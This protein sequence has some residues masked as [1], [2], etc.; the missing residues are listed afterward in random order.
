MT[1]LPAE[2][3]KTPTAFAVRLRDPGFTPSI[4]DVDALVELLADEALARAAERAI[5]RV[6]VAALD[7]LQARLASARPPIR[8]R[9]VRAIARLAKDER[10]AA[11]LLETLEDADP[12]TRRNAAIALGHFDGEP[13]ETALLR[14]WEAD[15]RPEMR[16]SLAASLGKVGTTVALPLLREAARAIDPELARIA[17]RAALMVERTQSRAGRGRIDASLTVDR[18]VDVI[19]LARH[20]LEDL[21]AEELMPIAGLT[22]VRILGPGRV[23][24]RLAGRMDGLFS[25]RTMLSFHFPLPT[26]TLRDGASPVDAI[27]RAVAESAARRIFETWTVG[28]VRYRISWTSGGHNRAKTWNTARAIALRSPEFIND[29]TAS[30]WEL[31]IS[32]GVGFVN[33]AIAPRALDDPRF[34]W[35]RADVPAASHPTIAAALARVARVSADDVVWDP[36]VGSGGELI[37]RALLG[38]CRALLGSDIDARA[39]LIARQNLEAS[40]IDASLFEADALTHAPTGVTLVLTNPPMGRRASRSAGLG[41]T[42]DR[43]VSHAASVLV[44]GGRL[45][46]MAPWPKRA[47]AAAANAG[48]TLDWARCVDMGG[49]D[50]ELQRWLKS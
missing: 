1:R 31:G 47:R 7:K 40:G 18:P 9:I 46:W 2:P 50:A 44:P 11:I 19:A 23:Y 32:T 28:P 34:R 4:R 29:P 6:G 22:S 41:E 48:L 30:T 25:A 16:R 37:E 39:L 20:G 17:G 8:G 27:A 10:A 43:F 35:R 13:I 33:V 38:P 3:P 49:F 14:A 12:K 42:L 36:F 5:G 45:V 21:L 15:P 26:E 24:A